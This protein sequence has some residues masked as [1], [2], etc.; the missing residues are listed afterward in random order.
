M[1]LQSEIS[2]N[3]FK[4]MQLFDYKQ[5]ICPIIDIKLNTNNNATFRGFTYFTT[6]L[7][8]SLKLL[9]YSMGDRTKSKKDT[10]TGVFFAL[11]TNE[12]RCNKY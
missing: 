3:G 2:F 5:E 1:C 9:P 11:Y 6:K 4:F 8:L 7:F 10:Y 12:R